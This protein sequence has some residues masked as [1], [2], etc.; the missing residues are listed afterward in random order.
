MEVIIKYESLSG[1]WINIFVF[2]VL[3]GIFFFFFF[4]MMGNMG[5]NNSCNLMSFGCSKVKAVNKEDIK[6]RFLDV[7]GVEEEK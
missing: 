5:G 3:F 6:V 1:M 2:I 7:V 4:L